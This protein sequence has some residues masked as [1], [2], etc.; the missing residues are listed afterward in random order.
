MMNK[1][2]AAL[3]LMEVSVLVMYIVASGIAATEAGMIMSSWDAFVVLM[4]DA[5]FSRMLY[6]DLGLTFL[7]SAIGAGLEAYVL[8]KQV[9]RQETIK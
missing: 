2:L 7:F 6:T 9:K 5:T 8:A 3:V 1:K 4:G